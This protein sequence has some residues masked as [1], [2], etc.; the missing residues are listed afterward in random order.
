MHFEGRLKRTPPVCPSKACQG[1]RILKYF[2][3]FWLG[4]PPD[5]ASFISYLL[6]TSKRELISPL[7]RR[8]LRLCLRSPSPTIL[9]LGSAIQT[10]IST[11]S[12][13]HEGMVRLIFRKRRGHR[14]DRGLPFL[15]SLKVIAVSIDLEQSAQQPS[16]HLTYFGSAQEK[17][18]QYY[19]RQSQ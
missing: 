6:I 4:F 5:K 14:S 8:E 18:V 13:E 16:G 10:V 15:S 1:R 2:W 19:S 12:A 9:A 17:M 11:P 3:R 7:H